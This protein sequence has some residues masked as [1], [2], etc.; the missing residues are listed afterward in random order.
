M[1]SQAGF[2]LALLE[3]EDC[4]RLL[5][6]ASLGRV[7]V[8]LPGSPPVI[9]P[10]NYVFDEPSQSVSFRCAN[11]SKLHALRH[12]QRAAFEV[13]GE[14][15]GN[16]SGWSVI[17]IGPVEEVVAAAELARLNRAPLRPWVQAALAPRWMRI[18]TTAISGR[19]IGASAAERPD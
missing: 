3:R 18:R 7:A 4:L 15:E 10:V 5:A 1:P 2:E 19:R 11:G 12:A 8:N 14:D 13:D 6:A 16:R 17:V 9:R